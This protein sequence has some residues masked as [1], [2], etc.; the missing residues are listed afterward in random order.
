[1]SY[2]CISQRVAHNAVNTKGDECNDKRD[3]DDFVLMQIFRDHKQ[4]W[5]QPW[6]LYSM[7]CSSL[8][9][10]VLSCWHLHELVM[11]LSHVKHSVEQRKMVSVTD[12]KKTWHWTVNRDN[13]TFMGV[14]LNMVHFISFYCKTKVFWK[15]LIFIFTAVWSGSCFVGP[16]HRELL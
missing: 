8:Q 12:F 7:T 16:M 15:L 5:Q 14:Y 13:Q 4:R 6:Q 2:S 11:E 10:I 1:M 3:S 9:I